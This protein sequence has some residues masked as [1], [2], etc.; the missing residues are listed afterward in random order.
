MPGEHSPQNQAVRT[1]LFE[2]ALLAWYDA[3]A[4]ALPWRD[5]VAG[6]RDPY[7]TWLS[8][9]L[10]QQTQVVR[11]A[12]YFDAFLR[13]FPTVQD[14]AA[15]SQDAVLE[16]WAG[17][18]YYARARNLHRAA[19]E[20]AAHGFPRTLEGWRALPGVGRYTAGAIVSLAYDLPSAVVDGNVRRV[21]ARLFANPHP[22]EE[23]L[24]TQ[25][26]AL[27]SHGRPGA[28]NEALIELGATVCTPKRPRCAAC[29]VVVHCA[30]FQTGTVDRV[31]APKV[32]AVARQI[33]AVALLVT[34]AEGVLL[35]PRPPDGL[36]GG[37]PGVPLQE[38]T[39]TKA[40]ALEGLLARFG[41]PARGCW[42]GTVKHAMTHRA[43]TVHVYGLAL[44]ASAD[45]PRLEPGERFVPVPTAARSR[46]DA[47]LI[48]ALEPTGNR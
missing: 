47:K 9:T 45:S 6:E 8:E 17:A 28:W 18:G 21:L 7:R 27:L 36:L 39:T 43:Y 22:S 23:W 16:V 41:L 40:A 46:L 33:E 20:I 14:L 35:E 2:T 25:A 42:I 34:Q 24:W 10:S 31:P 1:P 37:L 48:A 26:D 3:H 19:Q 32:R 13:A 15:A 11:G 4:R 44:E 5:R 38:I 30:A 12:L 29:P